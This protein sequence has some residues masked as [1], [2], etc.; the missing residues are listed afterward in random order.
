M[1]EVPE[2]DGFEGW[3]ILEL[4]GHRRLAGYC[5]PARIAGADMIRIDVPWKD[6]EK[7][8]RL[9]QFYG[10]GSIYCLTPCD[11]ATAREAAAWSEP[12]EYT[13]AQLTSGAGEE[14]QSDNG[15]EEPSW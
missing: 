12:R 13:T 8:N 2:L 1:T 15:G 6:P 3:A 5:R 7:G 10:G 14:S 4:M 9:T 11:E